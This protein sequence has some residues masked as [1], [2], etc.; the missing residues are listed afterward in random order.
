VQEDTEPADRFEI[1]EL[2]VPEASD[3]SGK[4]LAELDF[5]Q[6]F[7]ATVVGIRRG[8]EQITT[9]NPEEYLHGGDCLI[10]IG[11]SSTI[12]GLKELAPCKTV[13]FLGADDP[14]NALA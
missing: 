4:S 8:R 13:N 9:I 6:K 12:K 2:K 5:R 1:V 3:L 10:V 11:K 7:S 14:K